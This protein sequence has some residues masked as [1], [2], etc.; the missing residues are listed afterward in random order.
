MSRKLILFG[1]FLGATGVAFGAL[2]AHSLK[3]LI[4]TSSLNSFET[5]VRYQLVHAILLLIL[6]CQNKLESKLIGNL[7]IIGTFLFSF[8]IYLLSIKDL[9][10]LSEASILGPITPIGGLVLISSW[11][12]IFYKA[13]KLSRN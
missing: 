3:Q 11:V 5:G 13:L 10:N 9:L 12:I 2:G 1:S 6:G 8:S 4:S 7:V